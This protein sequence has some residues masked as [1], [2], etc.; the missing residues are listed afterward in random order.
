METNFFGPLRLIQAALP[1]LRSQK[2]GTIINFSSVAGF[3]GLPTCGLYAGSKFA[4]E[5]LS[6]SLSRELVPFNIKILIVQPGAFRTNFLIGSTKTKI[7]MS[8]PYKGS[9]VEETLKY[10]DNL[11]GTQKGDPEKAA[12][13]IF[14]V[15]TGTGMAESIEMRLGEKGNLRLPLGKDCLDRLETKLGVLRENFDE[16]REISLSTNLE[17]V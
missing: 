10:M 1:I 13:R 9:L 2:S 12:A 3:D 7:G 6:E 8:D 11:N 4:L 17:G 14:E 5:G 16:I 15:V